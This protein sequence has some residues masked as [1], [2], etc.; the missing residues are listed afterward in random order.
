MTKMFL[1]SNR[2][3]RIRLLY[4]LL[5]KTLSN[6]N[7]CKEILL[8]LELLVCNNAS[9]QGIVAFQGCFPVLLDII[10]DEGVAGGGEIVQVNMAI[11]VPNSSIIVPSNHYLMNPEMALLES[12]LSFAYFEF[13]FYGSTYLPSF[14]FPFSRQDCLRT[15]DAL[16]CANASNQNYFLEMGKSISISR[17]C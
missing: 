10:D 17:H 8:L 14:S 1:Y 16:L 9:I 3:L 15:L 12:P 11:L 2:A 4:P 13:I 7:M 5:F 6:M